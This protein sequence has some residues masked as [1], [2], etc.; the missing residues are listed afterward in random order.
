MAIAQKNSKGHQAWLNA[1]AHAG[2][3]ST[4]AMFPLETIRTRLAVDPKKYRNMLGAFQTIVE[5]EGAG[6]LYRVGLHL[7]PPR[8]MCTMRSV[9][10]RQT[11]LAPLKHPIQIL[12]V[13]A[14]CL[15]DGILC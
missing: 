9:L 15:C 13:I 14:S 1:C 10:L 8:Q 4:L 5:A 3:T 12:Q 11:F 7:N 6:A 2:L